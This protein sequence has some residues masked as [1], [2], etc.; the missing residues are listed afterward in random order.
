MPRMRKRMAATQG[1]KFVGP[2][3][4]WRTETG[5][6]I[7]MVVAKTRTIGPSVESIP[8]QILENK[9]VQKTRISRVWLQ[10]NLNT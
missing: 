3:Y 8:L 9:R 5:I 6:K 7:P 10:D 1:E 2:P 4:L